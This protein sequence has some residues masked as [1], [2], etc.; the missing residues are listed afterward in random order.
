MSVSQKLY[1]F[2]LYLTS[3]VLCQGH[4]PV[5]VPQRRW[6]GAPPYNYSPLLPNGAEITVFLFRDQPQS[7]YFL[8]KEDRSPFSVTVT[9]CDAALEWRLSVQEWLPHGAHRSG[10]PEAP[11]DL[12]TY[13]GNAAETYV[14]VSSP[15]ALYSLQVTATQGDTRIRVYMTTSPESKPPYPELPFDPRVHVTSVGQ[16]TVS[17]AWKASPSVLRFEGNIQYCLLVNQRHNFR[18]LCAAEAQAGLAGDPWPDLPVVSIYSEGRVMHLTRM[19]DLL[20][21]SQYLSKPRSKEH[22]SD[23]LRLCIG[24]RNAYQVWDLQPHTL[25]N[26]DV[27]AVNVL[28]N[29]SSAYTGTFAKT[30]QR[31]DPSILHLKEGMMI[32][33][34]VGKDGQ[35]FYSFRPG[36]WH[37]KVQFTFYSCGEVHVQIERNGKLVTSENTEN[38]KHFQLKGKAKARYVVGIKSLGPSGASV[39]ILVSTRPNKPLFPRLPH[40]LTLRTFD[41]LRTCNSVTVAWLG[42][43]EQNKYCLYKREIKEG[44]A[45]K[46]LKKPNRCLGPETRKVSEKVRCKYFH[47]FNSQRAVTVEKVTGL[48][49]GTTY[50][51]DVYVIGHR[52]HSVKYQSKV[53]K[54]R[55]AC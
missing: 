8:V 55:K 1:Q 13:T 20:L 25:Y 45:E 4:G 19:E 6:E 14:R 41:K 23:V 17:L 3:M 47:N 24:N 46:E 9:P 54:T 11:R 51:L 2:L 5:S 37:R 53:V 27:F 21:P 15:S 32:Q 36:N 16:S 49:A 48:V 33:V 22:K 34:N 31:P 44:Q 35:K 39:K 43:R 10:N 29:T 40:K 26:F 12:F 42:T 52:G 7:H 38:L 28:T 18:S 50:L 30:L